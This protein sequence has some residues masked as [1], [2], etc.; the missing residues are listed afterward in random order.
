MAKTVFDFKNK[1]KNI[2]ESISSVLA[3]KQV[4]EHILFQVKTLKMWNKE[5][6][7]LILG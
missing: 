1:N 7:F 2:Y 4:K 5:K 6:K 3:F